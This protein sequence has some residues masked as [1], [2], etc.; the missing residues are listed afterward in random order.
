VCLEALFRAAFG[1]SCRRR[2]ESH[3]AR[4]AREE[5]TGYRYGQAYTAPRTELRLYGY[6]QAAGR[7]LRHL[8]LLRRDDHRE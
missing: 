4:S 2:L 6:G 5:W 1:P 7:F 8:R 3:G